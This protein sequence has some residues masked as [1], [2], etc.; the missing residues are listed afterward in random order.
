MT[1]LHEAERQLLWRPMSAK[2]IT[3]RIGMFSPVTI[4]IALE[5]LVGKGVAIR[6]CQ[7]MDCGVYR[8]R[9]RRSIARNGEAA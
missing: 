2:E 6:D 9:Y 8:C 1:A 4:K 7:P 5:T 3:D